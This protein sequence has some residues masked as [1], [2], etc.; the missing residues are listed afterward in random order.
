[1]TD[2]IGQFFKTPAHAL[3]TILFIASFTPNSVN[4]AIYGP[5]KT[6]DSLYTECMHWQGWHRNEGKLHRSEADPA[7]A[8]KCSAYIRGMI[9]AY[10]GISLVDL[11]NTHARCLPPGASNQ[12]ILDFL[13]EAVEYA[14]SNNPHLDPERDSAWAILASLMKNYS[15]C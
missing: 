6:I 15:E 2:T 9:D 13:A 7:K 10:N 5:H 3:I 14:E 4:A 8:S 1:M 12:I 11:Q